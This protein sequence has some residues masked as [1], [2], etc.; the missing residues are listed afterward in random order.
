[1]IK[2]KILFFSVL[3]SLLFLVTASTVFADIYPGTNYEIV[4]NR[5]IKDINTGELLSFYT[6]ELRDAYLE[7]K[8]MYQTRSNATGVADYRTKYS[9]SYESSATSGA[10]SSTAYGGKA[11]ATLT[12]SAAVSFSAPES[13]F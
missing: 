2:L 6:T 3:S 13:G 8:S 10:L 11:G 12:L 5:I 4:S 9:H 1:M 7:S